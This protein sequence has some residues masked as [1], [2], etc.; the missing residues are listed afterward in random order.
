VITNDREISGTELAIA[1]ATNVLTLRAIAAAIGAP[2][3][4]GGIVAASSMAIASDPQAAPQLQAI[5]G[6]LSAPG[7]FA[8]E[9]IR[10]TTPLETKTSCCASCASGFDCESKK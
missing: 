2:G 4:V 10:S 8:V 9:A 1:A 6:F 5:A 3:W 7:A